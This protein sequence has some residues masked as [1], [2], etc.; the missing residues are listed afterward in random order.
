LPQNSPEAITAVKSGDEHKK[1]INYNFC[2]FFFFFRKKK[3]SCKF[4]EEDQSPLKAEQCIVWKAFQV[5]ANSSSLEAREFSWQRH[6]EGKYEV[7]WSNVK[8]MKSITR[9]NIKSGISYMLS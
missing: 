3:K 9:L 4:S 5:A 2:E 8:L 7:M 1:S 6:N